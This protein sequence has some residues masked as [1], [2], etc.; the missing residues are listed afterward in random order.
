[1][2]EWGWRAPTPAFGLWLAWHSCENPIPPL[3]ATPAAGPLD[4]R[5]IDLELTAQTMSQTF[6][7]EFSTAARQAITQARQRAGRGRGGPGP[8]SRGT[9]S[10]GLT[11]MRMLSDTAACTGQR[12]RAPATATV[13]DIPLVNAN[14]IRISQD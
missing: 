5:V 9:P 12:L 3:N 10:T 1:M 2:E 11:S 4:V 8:C 6:M 7:L 13:T 14:A